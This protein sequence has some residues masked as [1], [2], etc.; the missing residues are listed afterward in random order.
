MMCFCVAVLRSSL[1]CSA[2]R[3]KRL[4]TQ[5]ARLS[6]DSEGRSLL[7]LRRDGSRPS[8]PVL[9]R[10]V[11]AREKALQSRAPFHSHSGPRA[12]HCPVRGPSACPAGHA[13]AVRQNLWL[14][15]CKAWNEATSKYLA[16]HAACFTH[17]PRGRGICAARPRRV[18]A[19]PHSMNGVLYHHR[20]AASEKGVLKPWITG[21]CQNSASRSVAF[22]LSRAA[23][24]GCSKRGPGSLRTWQG[25]VL[26]LGVYHTPVIGTTAQ[27]T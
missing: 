6:Q 5:G 20:Q 11:K 27:A 4:A 12:T 19:N 24:R 13:S 18:E 17:P 14:R 26:H 8:K 25:G 21:V 22:C 16:S 9:S 23:T 15:V 3:C 7:C 1:L 2:H 10:R